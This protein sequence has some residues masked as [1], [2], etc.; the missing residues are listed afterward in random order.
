M[1]IDS[2]AHLDDSRFKDDR[3]EVIERAKEAGVARLINIGA[4]IESSYSALKLA[5]KHSF[6]FA[7][8][9][10][11]PHDANEYNISVEKEIIEMAKSQKVVAIGEIGLDYHYDNSPRELQKQAFVS[12]LKVAASLDLPVIIHNRE[13]HRDCL[14][15]LQK[16]N[17]D[18]Q[19]G[20]FHC[21]SGSAEMVREVIEM[22]FYVSFAGVITFKNAKKAVQ[23]LQMVPLDRLLF[24]TDCPYL[25]PEPYRGRRNEPAFIQLTIIKMAEV[26]GME[27]EELCFKV[28]ENT[29]RLF[30]RLPKNSHM[31]K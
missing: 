17:N 16:E 20:V 15:I 6:I 1:I 25:S 22:G 14:D 31:I 12:Q 10:V 28:W 8:V 26:L 9:G 13:A 23:A 24:E 18:R 29:H 5:E 30:S 27:Y 19:R 7:A 2:H 21:Y 11:H 4:D 3:N